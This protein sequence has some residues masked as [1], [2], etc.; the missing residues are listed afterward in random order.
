MTPIGMNGF[1][2]IIAF[3]CRSHSVSIMKIQECASWVFTIFLLLNPVRSLTTKRRLCVEYKKYKYLSNT[4]QITTLSAESEERC[5]VSCVRRYPCVAFNYHSIS[6]TCILLPEVTCM[7]PSSHYDN[8]NLF[9]HL[10]PCKQRPVW[11]SLRPAER[12][13]H[14]VTIDDPSNTS[15]VVKLPNSPDRYVSRTLYQGYY[16]P[17]WW[18]GASNKPFRAVYPAPPKVTMCPFGE[19]LAFADSSFYWWTSYT[20]GDVLPECALPLSQLPNGTPLY[21]VKYGFRKSNIS[22]L[23]DHLLATTYFVNSIVRN[24][25]AVDIL[26]GT[27][28]EIWSQ[29]ILCGDNSRAY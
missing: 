1:A 5:L 28:I 22:G 2:A 12:S 15:D 4:N 26:C 17:G 8:W 6:K 27:M 29:S 16:L 10:H 13:W 18:P 3:Q 7:T 9:V 23:Y 24:P 14:W 20:A 11:I 19:L 25:T 21:I